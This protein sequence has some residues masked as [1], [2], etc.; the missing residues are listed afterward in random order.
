M[1]KESAS[2]T[3]IRFSTFELDVRA[4]EL[5]KRGLKIRL[6]E[7]P[8]RILEMLLAHPRQLVTREELRGRLWPSDTFVDFEHGL[9]KAIAKV[10]DAL[11]DSADNP[12]FIETIPRRGYRFVSDPAVAAASVPT[13]FRQTDLPAPSVSFRFGSFE[14]QPVDR[15]LLKDGAAVPLGPRTFDLL[16][17][18]V[19]RAGHLVSKD[20]L[21]ERVWPGVVV[22][23]TALQMQVSL[24]RKVVG[25]D[26]IVTV[27]GHGYRFA[28]P[29][30]KSEVSATDLASAPRHNLS[31]YLTSFVGREHEIDELKG[32]LT[33]TRLV[34][35]TGAGGAGKTRLGIEVAWQLVED[36][37]DGVWLVE[38]AAIS[39]PA[40][41][42]QAVAEVL[43]QKELAGKP[44]VESLSDYLA[45]KHLL[46]VL[47]NTEHL[48]EGCAP[49]A[50]HILRRSERVGILATSRE[51]L[52]V[53]GE[54]TYRVPPLT[55]PE[56]TDHATPEA[57]SR[58]ESVRM[59][60][61]RARL[62]RP[63]FSITADNTSSVTTIC[64]R[65]DG[66]PLA[67]ELAAP[68]LRSM[69]IEELSQR[70]DQR[71]ALLTGGSRAA[72]PRHRTL[73]SLIDWSYD[74][75]S[76]I[77][78]ALLSRL[79]VFAGGWTLAS[80]EAVCTRDGIEAHDVLDL[81]ASLTDKNLIIAS[82]DGAGTRWR[83]LETV[84]Q[85]AED[86]L[87]ES[88]EEARWRDRHLDCFLAL[89]EEAFAEHGPG[90]VAFL[91]RVASDY[92]N[93]RGAFSWATTANAAVGLRLAVAFGG[94]WAN[95]SY[96]TEGRQ[97]LAG[98]LDAVPNRAPTRDRARVLCTAAILAVA[99][100]D[101]A[102]AKLRY[103]QCLALNRELDWPKGIVYALNG[104]GEVALAQA[105]YAE[106]EVLLRDA[107]PLARALG[108]MTALA[109]SL[110][111]L[112]SVM[113]AQGDLPAARLMLEEAL[114]AGRSSGDSYAIAE[115]LHLVGQVD[116]D[117]G[118]LGSA[119][120]HG[121]Q[122]IAIFK[123]LG[124]A[125]GIA[126]ALESFADL[127][128]ARHTP[129]RA[130]RI[131]GAAERLREEEGA[132]I[133]LDGQT[134]YRGSVDAAR[135]QLGAAVLDLAWREGRAMKTE[136]AILYALSE[137]VPATEHPKH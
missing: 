28:L 82:E 123:A 122:C 68:R 15:R 90:Q 49:L 113:R 56:A 21:L 2:S 126:A 104:L 125:R 36:L 17:V 61:E 33:T 95:S 89:A 124:N 117:G 51:P 44:L 100:A 13:F 64:R 77:E 84:R 37:R 97:W 128:M 35:L 133:L 116:Y 110:S 70:L 25:A 6:Q 23:D 96:L 66:I 79:S 65:L 85:Y 34:T 52:N 87:R 94:F 78:R 18:L 7:Q 81:L 91:E 40:L 76:D 105:A 48:L 59:F 109:V 67:I 99:Q 106:A 74:L 135:A 10:R 31:S 121:R 69:S 32:L 107:T 115:V 9:N 102:E 30:T 130:A 132:P 12:R 134:R 136:D 43:G 129:A 83:I 29:V 120:T 46:L 137:Q 80:A 11:G 55:I 127:A 58:Y 53:T 62:V 27:S 24:L 19:D 63:H 111:N 3:I 71:F 93:F 60:V 45:S 75:L 1:Q 54:L 108:D 5:R 42:P 16:T 103:E 14:L 57:L 131:W 92:D 22:I 72:L 98:L 39:D 114:A 118:D 47:D 88:G 119:E 20:E 41:V 38:L 4:G 86:R 112:G 50:D 73:R 26:A 8:L 101:Y